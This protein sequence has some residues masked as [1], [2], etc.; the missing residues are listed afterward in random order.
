MHEI[1]DILLRRKL[2]HIMPKDV[3]FTNNGFIDDEHEEIHPY[4]D[5]GKTV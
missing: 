5:N 2:T 1:Q 4:E 3:A